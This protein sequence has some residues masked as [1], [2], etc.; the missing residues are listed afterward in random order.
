[1][2][3]FAQNSALTKNAPNPL[4]SSALLI[5]HYKETL[6]GDSISSSKS[7]SNPRQR[8]LANLAQ[9]GLKRLRVPAYHMPHEKLFNK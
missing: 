5:D 9:E 1:L 7:I 3:G 2:N 8:K 6:Y 4:S